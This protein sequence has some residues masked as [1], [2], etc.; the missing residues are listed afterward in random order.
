MSGRSLGF[1]VL[2]GEGG[3]YMESFLKSGLCI[4]TLSFFCSDFFGG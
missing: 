1:R 2:S 4:A 3:S